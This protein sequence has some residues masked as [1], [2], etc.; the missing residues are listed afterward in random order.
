VQPAQQPGYPALRPWP[1]GVQIALRLVEHFYYKT[2]PVYDAMRKLTIAQQEA[3]AAAGTAAGT[4]DA[5][6]TCRLPAPCPPPP[7]LW[8][9]APLCDSNLLLT[10]PPW[11]HTSL[12]HCRM[13]APW[14]QTTRMRATWSR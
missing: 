11:V 5:V 6:S 4:A 1:C 14:T 13:P 8:L 10:P 3:D 7:P 2:A 12:A 9:Q